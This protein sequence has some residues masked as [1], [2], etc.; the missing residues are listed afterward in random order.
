MLL[1]LPWDLIVNDVFFILRRRV[2]RWGTAGGFTRPASTRRAAASWGCR[3]RR[4]RGPGAS[5]ARGPARSTCASC[6]RDSTGSWTAATDRTR[7]WDDAGDCTANWRIRR[8]AGSNTPV[9][10]P[11][12]Q[13]AGPYGPIDS[14]RICVG[15]SSG[16]TCLLKNADVLR[17]SRVNRLAFRTRMDD[18][19]LQKDNSAKAW[20]QEE[21]GFTR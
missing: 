4:P 6:G 8:I 14:R 2:Q 12:V 1:R 16:S 20:G 5:C 17:I 10:R 13:D 21:R 19:S 15:R 18:E 9:G 7:T 3:R 11:A